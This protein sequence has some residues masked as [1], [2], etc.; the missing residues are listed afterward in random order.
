M[1]EEE[2]RGVL[3]VVCDAYGCDNEL[4]FPKP[5]VDVQQAIEDHA[6]WSCVAGTYLCGRHARPWLS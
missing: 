3:V 1:A 2:N 6:E 5:G 4:V